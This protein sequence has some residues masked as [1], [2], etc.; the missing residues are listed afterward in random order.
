MYN[1]ENKK[2]CGEWLNEYQ[3]L[4]SGM[5]EDW[6]ETWG[7]NFP[8]YYAQIAPAIYDESYYS[9]GLRD[10]QRKTLESTSNTGM[11]ILMD[12]GE[13]NNIQAS[14]KQEV[15][16][17]LALLALENEYNLDIV[18]SG[19]LYKS[20]INY[21][22]YIE[23]DFENKGSGLYSKGKLKDFEIAGNNKVFYNANAKI[24]GIK[25]EY[26]PKK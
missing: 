8:F 1:K 15:G 16:K 12:I 11:A 23:I 20:S 2:N 5:I 6:R 4:F 14:S 17:R 10:A 25:L 21:K 3:E 19:P 13:K 18:S 9:F 26:H 22:K 24:F 7:Y